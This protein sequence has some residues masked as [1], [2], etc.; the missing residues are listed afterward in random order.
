MASP[1]NMDANWLLG[2]VPELQGVRHTL[3]VTSDGLIQ[4]HCP[5]TTKELA[6]RTAAMVAGLQSLA[7]GFAHEFAPKADPADART[8]Q[9][10]I[11]IPNGHV[12]LRP[13]AQ[14]S[15]LA[16]ITDMG[17]DPGMIAQ[18]MQE[19]VQKMG[20]AMK[21]SPRTPDHEHG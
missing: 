14:G 15:T 9:Q 6:D 2:T 21:T 11:S 1:D 13:A 7:K 17:A 12:F 18:H 5:S 19:Q 20:A 3:L 4:A 16:V 10:V 8:G